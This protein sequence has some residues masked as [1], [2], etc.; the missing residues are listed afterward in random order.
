MTPPPPSVSPSE[1]VSSSETRL[2]RGDRIL[3]GS[4]VFVALRCT[5]QYVLL[6]FI[7]PLFG[8]GNQ[9]SVIISLTLEI[10]ALGLMAYNV[11]QLWPTSWRWRYLALSAVAA[12]LVGIFIYTDIRALMGA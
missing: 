2:K 11:W 1:P 8:I 4:F 10:F 12:T 7:L 6:P 9:V 5:F 3:G